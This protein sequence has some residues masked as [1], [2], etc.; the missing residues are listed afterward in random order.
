MTRRR[1]GS[2]KAPL[3]EAEFAAAF[4]PLGDVPR[5]LAAVSGG[6][7][8]TALL[9]GL[10]AW[11]RA[12]GGPDISAATV[13]HGLRPGS[14]AEAEA[15]ARFAAHLGVPHTILT[16]SG[17]KAETVSQEAARQAR[18][19][20]LVDHARDIGATD[21]ATAHTLD[22]QAETLMMRLA[23]GSGL[24]GLVGMRREVAR[25]GIRH[26]RPLLPFSKARLLATCREHGWPFAE[27]P[28]NADPRFA[29]VRWRRE[30]L[31]LLSREGL[32]A[33]RLGR[34]AERL[35]R[36]DE[37]LDHAAR[38]VFDRAARRC[39]ADL[40]LDARDLAREP[41]EIVLRVLMRAVKDRAPGTAEGAQAHLRLERLEECLEALLLGLRS[42]L[43]VRRTLA[44]RLLHLDRKATLTVSPEGV[45]RR[46]KR[47]A[48]TAIAI[49]EAGSLGRGPGRP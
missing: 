30:L 14:Q 36:A 20:L 11:A 13:D 28:S 19:R 46:G 16:W 26:V 12:R 38:G 29:R 25:G 27:D 41:R 40:V 22:D 18:Y 43:S 21:L 35:S 42:G 17:R 31:P 10:A 7:D 2:G 49:P 8:S 4:S 3:G 48:V 9:G 1:P 6:P 37:A 45:R 32:D 23:A 15:V 24:S 44:G 34:L 47:E 39:G 5:I 33:G